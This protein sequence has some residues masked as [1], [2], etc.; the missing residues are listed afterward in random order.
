LALKRDDLTAW[1]GEYIISTRV[2]CGRSLQGYPFNPCLTEDQYKEMEEKVSS[3]LSGLEGELKG[4]FY[5]LTGMTKEVQQK[6]IDDHFLF[7]EGDRFL[8]VGV[9]RKCVEP[10]TG[11]GGGD[12]WP[13]S[14][15]CCFN[16]E[17]VG[18]AVLVTST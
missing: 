17:E 14:C 5:P 1:Q 6:L 9:N 8:Q 16:P 11:E 4:Q 10:G 2:R 7:K 18:N 12:E 15:L 13:V 3:T